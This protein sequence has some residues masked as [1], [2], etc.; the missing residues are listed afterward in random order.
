MRA[1]LISR[2][3]LY[4]SPRRL[5]FTEK[6][7]LQ[8]ILDEL[9]AKE[10]IRPSSS[11]YASP[12][13]LV[14][15]KNGE[16]RLC[17]DYRTLN[18]YI[19][20]M[21]YPMPV[22]E[23]QINILKDKSY[24]SILDLKDGFFHIQIAEESVKYTS[25]IT[26]LGQFEYIKMPFGLKSAPGRFQKFVNE[27]LKELIRSGDVI[28]YIDDFLIATK[29]LEHHLII[30]KKV[31]K[32]LVENKL[33]LR[34]DKCKFM[35]T[36]IE[37]LGYLITLEGIRP[38]TSGVEAVSNF[39]IPQSVKSVQSF[40]GLCSY[41]RKFIE[42]FSVIAKPLYDLLKKILRLCSRISS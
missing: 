27:V 21:N 6:E 31:F 39:P 38:T 17:I 19:A 28:A 25:F 14:K 35:F 34:I 29:S 22:I 4:F 42:G 15:K 30:L 10:V 16:Y 41:F 3:K 11:E 23:D 26:P 5:A 24:F 1:S 9:L 18:E 32:L 2:L 37:Y 8:K 36:E 40:L 12:I 7:Q 13:V 20:R 33:N